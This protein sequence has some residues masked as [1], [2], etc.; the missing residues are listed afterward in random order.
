[1][2]KITLLLCAFLALP[3]VAQE[4]FAGLATSKRVGILNGNMNPSEFANLGNRFEVQIFGLSVSA[5]SNKVGFSDLVGGEDLET[6]IFAGKE[7]VDFTTNA[8]IALPG[9]AFKA[10]G[11]GFGIAASGHITANVIDVNSDFGRA[12]TDNSLDATTAAAIINNTGNQRVNATVWGEVGFSA[13]RKIYE[14]EKHRFGGGV[15][16]KLLFP[17]SYAN[18]GAG[19][20]SG[21]ISYATGNPVLTNG[22]A[23][24]N[25]AYSGNFADSFTDSS[26]Y[27]S[28]LFGQLKGMATDI[29]FD[30]QWKSGSSYKLKVGASI[31]NIGSMTFKSDD[32]KSTNY[33]LDMAPGESLDL[34]EFD[35]AES[36]SDVEAVLLSHPEIFTETSETTDFKVKLPTVFNFYA[37]YNIVPKLNLTLFLQQ[38]M[39]KDD[40]NNQVASQNIFAL[41]PR[42]NL[43]FF[44]AFLP[45]SFNEIS[46]TQAGIGFR[47]S[48]F[49]L[50]SNSILT[51]LGDG[52]QADAYFGY[53]F[54]FL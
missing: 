36:L 46:D 4:H 22:Q 5:S 7:P 49:Y 13:A 51:A 35:N 23:R 47:L 38:K 15:T 21:D 44:E 2:R 11:W 26:D 43:G 32:N 29:G 25:L 9:F 41:T 8:E 54:G 12:V 6:L 40:K 33:E 30:Y 3:A 10:W 53:R 24:I 16:L 31:R 14:N 27:T 17:G 1:M 20:F 39:N 18:M 37:D 19:N 34:A 50:G 42:V 45:V 48:G 52:K 28:S